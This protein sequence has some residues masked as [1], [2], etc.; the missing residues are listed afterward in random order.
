MRAKY[1][2]HPRPDGG[3]GG[4]SPPGGFPSMTQI[5]LGIALR[6]FQYLYGHQ[7]YESS[8]KIFY[9]RSSQVKS[10]SGQTEVIF[11]RFCQKSCFS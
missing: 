8:E 10:Y 7:F 3:G 5:R 11:D 6:Q 1:L 4:Q 9:P 2:I